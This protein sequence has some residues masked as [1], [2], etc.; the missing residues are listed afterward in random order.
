MSENPPGSADAADPAAASTEPE[1]VVFAG[2]G[3]FIG[4]DGPAEF[5]DES[6]PAEEEPTPIRGRRVGRLVAIGVAVLV[7]VTAGTI[8][9]IQ[10]TRTSGSAACLVGSWKMSQFPAE[11]GDTGA[12]MTNGQLALSFTSK[13]QG[14]QTL[15]DIH[16]QS[17]AGP[18][19]VVQGNVTYS[20]AA[21]GSMITYTNVNGN[22]NISY[23]DQGHAIE[24][25]EPQS[26]MP[27]D[28]FSCSGDT[29]TVNTQ[30]KNPEVFIRA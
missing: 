11:L 25:S 26:D 18:N 20:Y 14:R 30:S 24:L 8:G 5:V 4:V 27:P 28:T 13:G 12:E 15:M 2:P 6:P 1:V 7:V 3:D 23:Q 16:V 22:I 17:V 21:S 10:L 29:L 19:S 9:T